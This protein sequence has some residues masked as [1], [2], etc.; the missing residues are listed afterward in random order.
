MQSKLLIHITEVVVCFSGWILAQETM[1]EVSF[2]PEKQILWAAIVSFIGGV[3]AGL[4]TKDYT[5]LLQYG[6][7]T[8]ILGAGL[9]M[10]SQ[11]WV[12]T[13]PER[14]W[15]SIGVAALLS[16]GGISSVDFVVG[17]LKKKFQKQQEK[18]DA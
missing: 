14:A 11:A 1:P 4:R 12:G 3:A 15:I 17:V 10:I 7:N 5:I 6:L 13:S 18:E 2:S 16:L 8:A 9:A